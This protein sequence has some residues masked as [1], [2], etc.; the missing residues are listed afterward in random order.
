MLPH[1]A[2]SWRQLGR[3]GG[4]L[5]DDGEVESQSWIFDQMIKL[6]DRNPKIMS[7]GA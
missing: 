3:L 4:G 6:E 1:I 7:P 5:M 2:E